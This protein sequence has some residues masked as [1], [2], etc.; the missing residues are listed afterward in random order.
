M[1]PPVHNCL[2]YVFNKET[3]LNVMNKLGETA[4]MIAACGGHAECVEELIAV[5]ANVNIK[6]K[7]GRTALML[8]LEKGHKDCVDLLLKADADINI[9]TSHMKNPFGD[10]N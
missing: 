2:K 5:G 6:G 10:G 1:A 4:L 7:D 3:D 8:A 9:S